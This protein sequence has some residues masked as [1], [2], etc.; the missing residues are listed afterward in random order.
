MARRFELA[1]QACGD[2]TVE[3]WRESLSK[4]LIEV[5]LEKVWL[6]GEV[7]DIGDQ[8]DWSLEV[9]LQSQ[10]GVDGSLGR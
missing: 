9:I 1:N 4:S 6:M 10:K 2:G 5:H 8:L 7:G 3:H